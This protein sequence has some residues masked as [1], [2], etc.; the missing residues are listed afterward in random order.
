MHVQSSHGVE[1]NRLEIPAS[2][3]QR[4]LVPCPAP[5]LG[6]PSSLVWLVM[7]R[8]CVIEGSEPVQTRPDTKEPV[9]SCSCS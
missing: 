7:H 9:Y 8:T 5:A 4:P 3:L 6:V 1:N 2:F